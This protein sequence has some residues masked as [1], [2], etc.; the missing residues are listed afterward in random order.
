MRVLVTGG[1]GFIAASLLRELYNQGHEVHCV[2][3]PTSNLWRVIDLIGKIT[4]HKVD[5]I[6]P[7]QV[8]QVFKK[9]RPEWIFHLATSRAAANDF[10]ALFQ[11]NLFVTA[12][13]VSACRAYPPLRLVVFGSSLEYGHRKQP[14][15]ETMQAQPS[16]LY[17][18]TRLCST[19]LFLQAWKHFALPVVIFRIFSV[20]GAWESSHR[21]LPKTLLAGI[22]GRTLQLT[23]PEIRRDYVLVDDL[24]KA[25]FIA[26]N[27]PEVDGEIINIG[28]GKQTSNEELVRLIDELTGNRLTVSDHEYPRHD[29]DTDHWV[30]D[31]KKCR[32]L[33]GWSP[34]K[35]ISKG[36]Q[37]TLEWVKQ[38]LELKNYA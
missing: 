2:V 29:T 5:L 25:A 7:T 1:A 37:L 14:L 10:D 35:D 13:L 24:I 11:G 22:Y 34:D 27:K 17:G 26:V 18:A 28:S 30:A 36:L 32:K 33:L 19:Q 23:V 15:C 8:E 4:I 20:Y 38:H 9:V 31:T 3:R 21:L 16:T 6:D 12:N